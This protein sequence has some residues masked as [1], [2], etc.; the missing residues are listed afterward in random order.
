MGAAIVAGVL[1][2]LGAYFV[3]PQQLVADRVVPGD[4]NLTAVDR[5]KLE[6]QAQNDE[7]KLRNDVRTTA[8]QGLG[9]IVLLLGSYFTLRTLRLNRQV[10]ITDTFS[11]AIGHLQEDGL[12]ARLG[13][14]HALGR[15]AAMTRYDQATVTEVLTAFVREH[16]PRDG[17]GRSGV[18]RASVQAAVTALGRLDRDRDP[19]QQ[20]LDLTWVDLQAISFRGADL[21]R[22]NL[23]ESDLRAAQLFNA[24][25]DGAL[26]VSADLRGAALAGAE[27][28][29]ASVEDAHLEGAD[30]GAARSLDAKTAHCAGPD[31]P[32]IR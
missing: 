27:F 5:A 16:A 11:T 2:F 28:K 31:R 9:G 7:D 21:R 6:L 14:I 26:L 25:L 32:H 24:R 20:R 23:T 1:L 4:V 3:L 10:H 30:V 19:G 13:G 22:A 8:V 29:G 18:D 17:P 15:V 12:V